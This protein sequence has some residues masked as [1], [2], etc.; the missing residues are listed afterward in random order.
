MIPSAQALRAFYHL[1]TQPPPADCTVET[2]YSFCRDITASHYENFPVGSLLIPKPLRPHVAA[3][4]SFARVSDDFADEASYEGK[5]LDLLNEWERKL[6]DCYQGKADHP[7]FIALADTV[8]KYELPAD[9]FQGLLR[10]FKMDVTVKRYEEFENVLGYCRYSANPV[11]RLILY[12]FGYRDE[13]LF[14]LSDCICTALQLTNF[15]QDITIDQKKDRIYI[16]KRD[17]QQE[18]YSEDE[19]FAQVFDERFQRLLLRQIERTWALF[20]RGYPLVERVHW[21][22]SAELRLTWL[23][24][25]TILSRTLLNDCNAFEKRPKLSKW[26]FLHLGAY[27]L[28]GIKSRRE[29]LQRLFAQG[30]NG[31]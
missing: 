1:K 15:W 28:L 3:I 17:M 11:G 2:A 29:R 25:A 7:I 30:I 22:L 26:D 5:R 23:T 10:A 21:P 6:I 13:E 4:Y 20:D 24:G 16:P 19:Y 14:E 9:L 18:Q 8:Q 27:S 31:K 12:L